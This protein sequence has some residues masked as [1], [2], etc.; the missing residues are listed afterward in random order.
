MVPDARVPAGGE[1][2]RR[3]PRV[4]RRAATR[5]DTRTIEKRLYYSIIMI[6]NIIL[7]I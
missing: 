7:Q 6:I 1:R 4:E 5:V 2:E 3:G